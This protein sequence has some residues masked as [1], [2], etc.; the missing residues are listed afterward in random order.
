MN[1]LVSSTIQSASA[2]RVRLAVAKPNP[3]PL[4]NEQRRE[5]VAQREKTQAEI[6]VAVQ[7]W[8]DSTIA[9]ANELAEHFNKKPR[10]FLDIFFHG[11]ARM[12][13]HHE[14]VNPHN[15]FVS[16]KAQELREAGNDDGNKLSLLEIQH[17]FKDEYSNLGE[18]ERLRLVHEF[19]ETSTASKRLVRPSPRGRVQDVANVV[20]NMILLIEG[21]KT[22]TGVE[23]FFCIVRNSPSYHINPQWYFSSTSL[24]DYM[25]LAVANRW[26][27]HELGLKLEAFAIAGC[28]PISKWYYYF[29][30][31]LA[32]CNLVKCRYVLKC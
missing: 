17:A 28:N 19:Q 31:L 10:Y 24:S 18:E 25:R 4:T 27:A 26:N 5:K 22:R 14:K 1:P 12:V 7:A 11:G 9:K 30:N 8:F 16:L 3:I 32:D 6:D 29:R 2:P 15:A 21:L 20:R 13:M 23:G